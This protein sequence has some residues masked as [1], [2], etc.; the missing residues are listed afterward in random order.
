MTPSKAQIIVVGNEKGGSGKSTTAI[1]L[2]V[3][4]LGAGLSVASLDLDDRQGTLTRYLQLQR[5]FADTNNLNLLH[6]K[7]ETGGSELTSLEENSTENQKKQNSP[8]ATL[9]LGMKCLSLTPWVV[10][11]CVAR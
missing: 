11:I 6:P 10:A 4:L 3:G 7:Y 5:K 9:R 2:N 8:S 1:H